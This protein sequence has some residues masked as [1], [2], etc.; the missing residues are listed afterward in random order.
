M[1][2][3]VSWIKKRRRRKCESRGW[4]QLAGQPSPAHTVL[5]Q[6]LQ[7]VRHRVIPGPQEA[8][9]RTEDIPVCFPNAK[10]NTHTHQGQMELTEVIAHSVRA[11]IGEGC[12]IGSSY[13]RTRSSFPS[14]LT[15]RVPT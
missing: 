15:L 10:R 2:E 5:E 6:Q 11:T 14:L 9:E 3:C 12:G 8:A 4:E 1:A 7:S 13:N